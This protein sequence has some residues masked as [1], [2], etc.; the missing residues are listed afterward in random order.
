MHPRG[1]RVFI[2]YGFLIRPAFIIS[3]I[4]ATP[5]W[6]AICIGISLLSYA[7]LYT[8]VEKLG[9]YNWANPI[10]P[11]GTSTL[12]CYL[13][14]IFVYPILALIGFQW[15]SVLT[16]SIIGILKSLLFSYVLILIVGVMEKQN[17]RLKI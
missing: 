12:T 8:I 11:A 13:M 9:Y 16:I 5:S 7:V 14:S 17:I 2:G 15:P 6:T 4:L 3:K 10:K 1:G